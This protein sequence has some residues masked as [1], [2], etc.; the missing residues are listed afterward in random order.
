VELITKSP[1]F[2]ELLK[3]ASQSSLK[4]P[5]KAKPVKTV[6]VS[7]LETDSDSDYEQLLKQNS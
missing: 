7:K 4:Q 3:S 2:N 5:R 1:F 6:K